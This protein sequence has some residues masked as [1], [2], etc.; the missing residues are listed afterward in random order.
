MTNA[1][2]T[3][4]YGPTKYLTF[5]LCQQ[6]AWITWQCGQ[7]GGTFPHSFRDRVI[8]KEK[9]K[10]I[11][12]LCSNSFIHS[13]LKPTEVWILPNRKTFLTNWTW[14]LS[15]RWRAVTSVDTNGHMT[16]WKWD[17]MVVC[18]HG[19]GVFIGRIDHG[20]LTPPVHKE[21]GAHFIR[22]VST[23]INY[24]IPNTLPLNNIT[25]EPTHI[26]VGDAHIEFRDY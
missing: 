20:L 12:F 15:K 19:P 25:L 21:A 16:A 11:V 1:S 22:D 14:F 4:V 7:K 10:R 9:A 13:K 8:G 3:A 2:G 23:F 6:L 18:V 5:L 26:R 17:F 24:G